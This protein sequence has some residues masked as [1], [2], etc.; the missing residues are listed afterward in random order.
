MTAPLIAILDDEPEIV[1]LLAQSLDEAGFRTI[2]FRRASDLKAA[3]PRIEPAV[4][5]I[6]LSLPDQDGL[7]L[8]HQIAQAGTSAVMIIS[9]RA[10]VQDKVTG[11]ELGADDYLTKPFDAIEVVARVRALIRR[12]EAVSQQNGTTAAFAGWSANFSSFTL[13]APDGHVDQ[14]SRAEAE[15]LH[16]FLNAPNRLLSRSQIQDA[17]GGGA[18][19][20]IDRAIDVRV[21]RLRT[22]LR[23]DP[24][25]PA[26][27]KTIYGAGYLFVGTVNWS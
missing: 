15:L 19:E 11:L 10:Q 21:S 22:K 16:L 3:L 25:A 2:G 23:D 5:L 4:I 6:D 8:V 17:C 14:L 9:G 12:R 26:L 27:I 24:K 20:T 18:H 13:T 7:A 1:R